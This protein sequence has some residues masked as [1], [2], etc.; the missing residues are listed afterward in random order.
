M[1]IISF[2]YNKYLKIEYLYIFLLIIIFFVYGLTLSE[3]ID[4]IFH[5]C[6]ESAPKYRIII[7][8]LGELGFV[9][10]IYYTLQKYIKTL[11]DRLLNNIEYI[12]PY[13]DQILLFAFSFGIYKHLQKSNFKLIFLKNHYIDQ[14]NTT[15]NNSVKS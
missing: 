4:F 11:I 12:V 2:N 5:D 10:L 9:Y 8:I 3:F 1:T 15:F 13:F 14:Y 7:E 6:D